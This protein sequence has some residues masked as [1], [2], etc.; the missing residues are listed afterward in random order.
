MNINVQFETED[1]KF[2]YEGPE[3]YLETRIRDFAEQMLKLAQEYRNTTMIPVEEGN[4]HDRST[5]TPNLPQYLSALKPQT[6]VLRFLA[7]ATWLQVQ[8]TGNITTNM[9]NSTLRRYKQLKL[10]N[11][12]DCL[13]KNIHNGYCERSVEEPRTFFVTQA[14]LDNAKAAS[15]LGH[16]FSQ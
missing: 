15:L 9:V 2:S 10:G 16:E 3:E 7:T 14:G 1:F 5:E 12:S 8:G 6:Q 13:Q 4:A 11:A